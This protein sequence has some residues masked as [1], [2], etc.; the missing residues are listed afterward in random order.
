MK[1]GYNTLCAETDNG[2]ENFFEVGARVKVCWTKEE[3]GNSGWQPGWYVAEVQNANSMLDQ[4]EVIYLSESVYKIDVTSMLA[5]GK[6]QL[7]K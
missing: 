2:L 6:L 5:E 7:S 3:I 4:I 1:S